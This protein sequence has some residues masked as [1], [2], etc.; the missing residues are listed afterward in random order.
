MRALGVTLG[1]ALVVT[2]LG[3]V[4]VASAQSAPADDHTTTGDE[5]SPMIWPPSEPYP[6]FP[7]EPPQPIIEP[8]CDEVSPPVDQF[9]VLHP[10]HSQG[11]DCTPSW[12]HHTA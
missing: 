8:D 9:Y 4:G 6:P 10:I 7:P 5:I 1:M 11:L 3:Q 2:G 12:E